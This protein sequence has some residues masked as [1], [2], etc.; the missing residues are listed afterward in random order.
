MI[1]GAGGR[2]V[3]SVVDDHN[4]R[5]YFHY[6]PEALRRAQVKSNMPTIAGVMY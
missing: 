5:A 1:A 3:R 6:Q 4:S 2:L